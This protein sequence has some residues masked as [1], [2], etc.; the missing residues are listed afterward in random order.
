[1]IGAFRSRTVYNNFKGKYFPNV[2]HVQLHTISKSPCSRYSTQP[3]YRV[4]TRTIYERELH[5]IIFNEHGIKVLQKA[6][7][8]CTFQNPL[9]RIKPIEDHYYICNAILIKLNE[10]FNHHWVARDFHIDS[11]N[12]IPEY[13][14]LQTKMYIFALLSTLNSKK[15]KK[16]SVFN[17]KP[18]YMGKIR[19][20]VI[21]EKFIKELLEMFDG[22]NDSLNIHNMSTEEWRL[23]LE[24]ELTDNSNIP[25]MFDYL[26]RWDIIR[27]IVKEYDVQSKTYYNHTKQLH[28]GNPMCL[29]EIPSAISD[30]KNKPPLR[31]GF[32][33]YVD[34]LYDYSQDE[35]DQKYGNQEEVEM[36]LRDK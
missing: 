10:V 6:S 13:D 7:R 20:F 36:I 35:N 34:P 2:L 17:P 28:W 15:P 12:D 8:K 29:L 3:K 21:Q 30:N 1:M 18:F 9:I 27:E 22:S 26:T 32:H 33:P 11:I 16:N 31:S 25:R 19:A 24:M 14:I 23:Y 5:N 4:F